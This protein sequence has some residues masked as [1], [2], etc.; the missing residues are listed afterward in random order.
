MDAFA[1]YGSDESSE[2]GGKDAGDD[3]DEASAPAAPLFKPAWQVEEDDDDSDE[4]A[5]N[6]KTAAKIDDEA[7][8]KGHDCERLQCGCGGAGAGGAR[9]S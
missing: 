2:A 1:G 5:K 9:K 8:R 3:Q 4:E 6:A 7:K